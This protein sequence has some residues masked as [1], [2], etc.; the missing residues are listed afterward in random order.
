MANQPLTNKQ[1]PHKTPAETLEDKR[2]R[3]AVSAAA[4]MDV[5]NIIVRAYAET[6]VGM[7]RILIRAYQHY[8]ENEWDKA[9]AELQKLP[10]IE[11]KQIEQV[12]NLIAHCEKM[13]EIFG[14]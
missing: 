12:H 3:D 4:S 8:A 9:I 13:K 7:N 10:T 11:Y 2:S 5:V 1:P 14:E 6:M